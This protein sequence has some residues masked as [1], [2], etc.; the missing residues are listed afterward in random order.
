MKLNSLLERLSVRSLTGDAAVKI[1]GLDSDSRKIDKGYLFVAVKG[2][3]VDGHEYINLAVE[4]GAVAVV[5]EALPEDIMQG[6]TYVVVEDSKLA[7]AVLASA[8]NGYPSEHI[9]LVGVTGTNGK[10]T[11]ATLL[12]KLFKNLGYKA[13]LLS[14]VC[15]YVNDTAVEATHTT[16]DPVSLNALLKDMVG[17]GC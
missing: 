2:N 7:I 11:I 1:S 4:K 13:G 5:C 8:W 17:A 14:T 15:N 3:A 12:Y 10:T 9:K 16:P 6:V